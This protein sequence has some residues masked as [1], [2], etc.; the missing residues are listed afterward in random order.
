M[1]M[2][3]MHRRICS[4]QTWADAVRDRMPGFVERTSLGDDV[5]EIGP[6]FGTTTRAMV[7]HLPALT[8]V[9]IDPA[10]V[11]RLRTEFGGRVDVVLGD[12]TA[13]AVPGRTVLRGGLLHDAAPRAVAATARRTVRRG[14][15]VTER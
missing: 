13:A 1:P 7:G 10:S 11:E 3:L 9:E 8:C 12:G 15:A 2:N 4:S 5:L 6:G 14:R